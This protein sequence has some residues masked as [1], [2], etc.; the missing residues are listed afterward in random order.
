MWS[1][2]FGLNL[3]GVGRREARGGGVVPGEGQLTG[4]RDLKPEPLMELEGVLECPLPA[5]L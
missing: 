5:C 4:S 1:N 2:R 3:L